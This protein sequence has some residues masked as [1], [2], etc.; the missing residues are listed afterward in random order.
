MTDDNKKD[1]NAYVEVQMLEQQL[2]Q[3]QEYQQQFEN[4]LGN[5]AEI[6]QS[7][8]EFD[9]LQ[10]QA[11]LLVP[12]QNGIF[13][14]ATLG[15]SKTVKINVGSNTIVDKTVEEAKR[16]MEQQ[17]QSVAA[18]QEKAMAQMQQFQSRLEELQEKVQKQ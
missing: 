2:K 3:L 8:E 6:M 10:P 11:P 12:L 15:K 18:N 17:Q 13:I 5:I 9:Q 14:E 16:L 1:I 7:L 4:Q